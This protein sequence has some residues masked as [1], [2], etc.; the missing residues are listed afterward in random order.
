[1]VENIP[2]VWNHHPAGFG[3]GYG[4]LI[5]TRNYFDVHLGRLIDDSYLEEA[6]FGVVTT[7]DYT[8]ALTNADWDSANWSR[9]DDAMGIT[10]TRYVNDTLSTNL[11]NWY[12]ED[13]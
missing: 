6:F 1:M 2:G 7:N 8:L 5:K 3:Q 12:K 9:Y 10:N 13:Y 4:G 11:A